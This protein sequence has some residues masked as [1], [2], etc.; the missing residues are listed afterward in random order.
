MAVTLVPAS[1]T[2]PAVLDSFD[3]WL[4]AANADR[5]ALAQLVANAKTHAATKKRRHADNTIR[6]Y[7]GWWRRFE[8]WCTEPASRIRG[9]ALPAATPTMALDPADPRGLQILLIFLYEFVHGPEDPAAHKV[10]AE[11][12]GPVA[13]RTLDL[14]MSAL[15]ARCSDRLG[16]RLVLTKEVEDA[17]QGLRRIARKAYGRDRRATPL[18]ANHLR[19]I[20]QYLAGADDPTVARDR[21]LLELAAVGVSPAETARL[22]V[23]GLLDPD[24]D[25]VAKTAPANVGLWVQTGR[26]GCRSLLIPGRPLGAGRVASD[27]IITLPPGHPLTTA[28]DRWLPHRLDGEDRALIDG[29][30]KTNPRSVHREALLAL[31]TDAAKEGCTWRP[32]RTTPIP[33]DEDLAACRRALARRS[34]ADLT[35]RQRDTAAMWIGWRLALRRSELMDLTVGDLARHQD[36]VLVEI[37]RSKTDQDGEGVTL[38]IVADT[39]TDGMNPLQDIAVWI[40]TLARLHGFANATDLPVDTPMFPALDRGQAILTRR[41]SDADGTLELRR[42][43]RLS[44][45]GWSDRVRFLA[46]RSGAITEPVALDR[47]S[48]HSLRRGYITSAAIAGRTAI[49]IRRISRHSDLNSLARYVEEVQG[50]WV[51]NPDDFEMLVPN[52]TRSSL[53]RD[54]KTTIDGRLQGARA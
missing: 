54:L 51:E 44:T 41:V 19:T 38:P 1:S 39:R 37:R 40:D 23:D 8:T 16:F 3:S 46:E 33:G 36:R 9:R 7:D 17:L 26:V 20:I 35:L 11:D 45:Q 27:R 48:G 34:E 28:V 12:F 21:L 2:L 47:V 32:S 52:A 49:Q 53:S 18:L 5:E 13:P 22:S 42:Y 6:N 24:P 14:A 10:W 31:A 15:K 4:D 29:V 30:S 43:D 25:L 50:A